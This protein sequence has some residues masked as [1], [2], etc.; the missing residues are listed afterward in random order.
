MDDVTLLEFRKAES[1]QCNHYIYREEM[2]PPNPIIPSYDFM[3]I[4]YSVG[5]FHNPIPEE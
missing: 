2:P 4:K 3:A 5:K 1:A